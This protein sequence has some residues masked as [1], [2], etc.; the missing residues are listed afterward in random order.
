MS[1]LL[2]TQGLSVRFGG[3]HA[4]SDVDL[5]VDDGQ[6]VGLIGPNGAGKT[7]FIDAITG[8]VHSTGGVQ[9][10]G[11]DLTHMGP[12]ERA[13]RGL[14]RTWQ[15]AELF[16]DLTVRENLHVAARRA[17]W[18]ETLRDIFKGAETKDERVDA[19]LDLLHLQQFA[20]VLPGELTQGQRKLVGVG[21]ALAARPHV[22]CLDEPAAGLDTA[23]SEELGRRLRGVVDAGTAMLL[24]DHDMGLVLSICDYV[25]V[26][27]FGK[28]IAQGTPDTV[29]RDPKVVEAYLGG[30]GADVAD[31][32]RAAADEAG[33]DAGAPQA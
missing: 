8:F 2:A 30:A 21:R 29:T 12:D 9:L 19:A 10:E 11:T 33:H 17:S 3:V 14:T 5:T 13:H 32:V 1:T 28:V 16:D 22:V 15:A 4:L 27:E 25:V 18:K 31:E 7:T 6:L 23:E 20:D 26:L 24:I